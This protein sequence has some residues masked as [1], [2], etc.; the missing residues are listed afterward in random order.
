M[1]TA[2]SLESMPLPSRSFTLDGEP[3]S[4]TDLLDANPE[5]IDEAFVRDV[6]SLS[7]GESID[8]GG[9]A[10]AAFVLARVA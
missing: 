1:Q 6:A 10:G 4:L 7:V 5:M 9:G 3:V 2:T 8:L